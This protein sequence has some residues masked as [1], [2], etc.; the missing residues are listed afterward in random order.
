MAEPLPPTR[1]RIPGSGLAKGLA[2]TLRT[3][4]KKTVTAQY[5][6]V[7]PELPPRSRGVIGLFEENCTVCML[8]ARECPDWCIY[9]DSHKETVPPTAPGGRERSRNVLDRFAIDFSLCMYCGICIEVCPFD[10]LFWSPEFEYAETD[11]HELTHERDK[12]REWMWTVPAPPALDPG[13]EE[14]KELAAARKTADKLAAEAAT[15]AELAARTAEQAA[16]PEPPA[17]GTTTGPATDETTGTTTGPATDATTGTT[18]GTTT[19]A[20]TGT[21]SGTPEP[22]KPSDPQ[23]GAS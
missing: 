14:P 22:S 20:T 7:Q 1:S 9:I 2:V 17:G 21:T 4:T 13:A 6:D 11:I 23:D 8:C 5:P 19:D 10:A 18:S 3:M 15:A 16:Q 12:L